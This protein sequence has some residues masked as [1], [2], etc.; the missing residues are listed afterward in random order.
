MMLSACASPTRCPTL[1]YAHPLVLRCAHLLVLTYLCTL[2]Y[3]FSRNKPTP[4]TRRWTA[5]KPSWYKTGPPTHTHGTDGGTRYKLAPRSL[6]RLLSKPKPKT[7]SVLFVRGTR[8]NAFD[9]A[10]RKLYQDALTRKMRP[11]KRRE[12]DAEGNPIEEDGGS[13]S[14]AEEEEDEEAADVLD[15][16]MLIQVLE[17]PDP[18]TRVSQAGT[19]Y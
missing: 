3:R 7:R 11:P 19:R 16:P 15:V 5:Y 12:V 1:G 13:A 9:S 6:R 18:G 4:S 17:Y 8:G 10:L 2:W 14:G